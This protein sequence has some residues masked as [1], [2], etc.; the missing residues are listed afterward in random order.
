MDL[1]QSGNLGLVDSQGRNT[2]DRMTLVG[3]SSGPWGE[4][5]AREASVSEALDAMMSD[6]DSC[7]RFVNAAFLDVGVGSAGS[8]QIVTIGAE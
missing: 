8:V 7:Q 4:S 2:Q 3:Y 6:I 1:G 5:F